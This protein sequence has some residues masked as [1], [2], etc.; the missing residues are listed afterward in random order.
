MEV[1]EAIPKQWGNSL[2]VTIPSEIIKKEHISS[3]KK[4]RFLVVGAEMVNLKKAFGTM[5]LKKP[6]QKAMAEIDEGYD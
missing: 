1:F 5:K 3:K 2:G 6:T 4:V